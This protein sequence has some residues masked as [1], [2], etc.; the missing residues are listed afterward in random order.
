MNK[1]NVMHAV[2]GLVVG[3][4]LTILI[5]PWWGGMMNSRGSYGNNMMQG[6]GQ[7]GAQCGPTGCSTSSPVNNVGMMG[8]GGAGMMNGAVGNGAMLMNAADI[9]KAFIE[10]MIPHHRM[11]VMMA[12][13][14]ATRT[15]RPEMKKLAQDI[16]T[17]QTK[18][19]EMM[20]AW[21]QS[22]YPTK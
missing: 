11:A 1:Q 15:T 22:W 13:M 14:L 7:V 5:T 2:G 17:A 3:V 21:Y 10:E 12:N 18:E 9:D 20:Q 16:I 6:T 4:I 19:I 8:S